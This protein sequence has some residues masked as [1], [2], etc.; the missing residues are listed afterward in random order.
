MEPLASAA[1]SPVSTETLAALQ[2]LVPNGTPT[3]ILFLSLFPFLVVFLTGFA[4]VSMV[5]AFLRHGLGLPDLPSG[6][7]MV[8]L[9]TALT[10]VAMAPLL[11]VLHNDALGPLSR[12]EISHSVA[13]QRAWPPL[14]QF[15]E[16]ETLEADRALFRD[17]HLER[18]VELD[19][20]DPR[21]LL[22]AFV[23][24]E[25][26]TAFQLGMILWIPFLVVDL[27]LA[28][29]LSLVGLQVDPASLAR[30]LKVLLFLSVSGWSLVV[31]GLVQSFQG[32]L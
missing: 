21:T 12:Q 16:S 20:G 29:L 9:A 23:V 14:M 5:L 8:S 25:L 28:V 1:A 11:E 27:A 10:L 31:R 17:L 18:G 26:R 15:L 19:P 6:P 4:R 22:P 2:T 13:L 32:G 24:S 30:P 7:V 3:W